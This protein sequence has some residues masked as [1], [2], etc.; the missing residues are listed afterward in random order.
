VSPF[1]YDL[2]LVVISSI[3]I[4]IIFIVI[5]AREMNTNKQ[6]AI[7]TIYISI[8]G[9]AL[10]AIIKGVTGFFGNSYALIADA[11]ESTTDVFASVL[12]LFG[13]KYS[14][15]PADEN[16]PYGHGRAEPLI[17][18]IVVGFLVISA[19]IIAYKSIQNIQTPHEV[20]EKYT[21]IVL[22]I[23]VVVKE[24]FYR[25]VSKKSDE[26][27]STSLK[28][29]AWHHRSDAITSLMAFIGIS[30]AIFMGKG[31]EV[32]DDYAA[33]IASGFI[34]YNSYLIFRP[35]LGEIMDEHVYDDLVMEIRTI[36][37]NVKGVIDTEKCFVRKAGIS[38]HV[39]LHLI[40]KADITV[41]EGHKIAHEL[42]D[43]L[44]EKLPEISDVLIHVEP[45]N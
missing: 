12:V 45:D 30:I 19:T 39:D 1:F 34:V 13:L 15:K 8:F 41:K 11:I 44:Q 9:N 17:T 37:K 32:A 31:Y 28:A 23:I 26:T 18:F 3:R 6:K 25:I 36:A 5:I 4:F 42:K 16:H 7:N 27:K 10:L 35:A 22:A 14:T 33:L 38:F 24:I 43:V 21:L 20:P 40:V 2:L 29:D